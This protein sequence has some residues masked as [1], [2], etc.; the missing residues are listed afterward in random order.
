MHL[1]IKFKYGQEKDLSINH[2][3]KKKKENATII[4]S[5]QIEQEFIHS[6]KQRNII[7]PVKTLARGWFLS[8]V[9]AGKSILCSGERYFKAFQ[10]ST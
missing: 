7:F 1:C 9:F 6:Y 3:R 2:D 4:F 5:G 10:A 8:Q